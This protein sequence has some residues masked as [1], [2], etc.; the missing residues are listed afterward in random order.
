MLHTNNLH[1]RRL[2]AIG[3]DDEDDLVNPA[4][5]DA[6]VH[7]TNIELVVPELGD[8]AGIQFENDNEEHVVPAAHM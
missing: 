2:I 4:E 7:D 1:Y 5:N 8:N 3:G 6:D